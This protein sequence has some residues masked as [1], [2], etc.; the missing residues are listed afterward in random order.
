MVST[1]FAHLNIL[2][3]F[4]CKLLNLSKT[5][6]KIGGFL[7]RISVWSEWGIR[8]KSF[9]YIPLHSCSGHMFK[10]LVFKPFA[11]LAKNSSIDNIWRSD[12][13]ENQKNAKI[14][15]FN[16]KYLHAEQP[17]KQAVFCETSFLIIFVPSCVSFL[18]VFQISSVTFPSVLLHTWFPSFTHLCCIQSSSL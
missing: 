15:K 2:P 3:I 17:S 1:R 18:P 14:N 6:G 7:N 9:I 16:K 10:A 13:N 8:R 4:L 11:K 5:G 12:L